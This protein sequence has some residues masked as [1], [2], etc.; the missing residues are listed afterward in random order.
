MS[1][2]VVDPSKGCDL[3]DLSHVRLRYTIGLSLQKT[4]E[5]H[6]INIIH[7]GK[8]KRSRFVEHDIGKRI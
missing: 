2:H 7:F 3:K 8:L 5:K 6:V 4:M 1:L